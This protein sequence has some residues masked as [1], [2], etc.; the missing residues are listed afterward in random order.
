MHKTC[1]I[2][3]STCDMLIHKLLSLTC[4]S[5]NLS[6]AFSSSVSSFCLWFASSLFSIVFNICHI[7]QTMSE[8]SFFWIYAWHMQTVISYLIRSIFD[9]DAFV[10]HQCFW[11]L[12]WCC[13]SEIFSDQMWIF[14]WFCLMILT[15]ASHRSRSFFNSMSS[16][17][18][19]RHMLFLNFIR[20]HVLF[21][22]S[23]QLFQPFASYC[24][25]R[26]ETT[27]SRKLYNVVYVKYS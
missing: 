27:A 16:L 10:V 25:T 13:A 23:T 24:K 8:L 1:K 12:S 3:N 18:C 21:S 7:A 20:R 17:E 2:M 26:F 22:I 11:M 15:Y 6:H 9:V 14:L 5:S 4:S 19:A